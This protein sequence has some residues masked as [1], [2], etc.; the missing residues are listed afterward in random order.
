MDCI[1]YGVAKAQP[2]DYNFHTSSSFY[3]VMH[4]SL[5]GPVLAPKL[6]FQ[7]NKFQLTSRITSD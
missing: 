4:L 7:T 5:E 1:V 3:R 6:F 2:N